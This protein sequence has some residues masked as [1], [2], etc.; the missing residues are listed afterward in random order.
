LVSVSTAGLE[1]RALERENEAPGVKAAAGARRRK[2]E[3]SFMVMSVCVG[4]DR[5]S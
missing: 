4:D 5:K 2:A 1:K 3:D